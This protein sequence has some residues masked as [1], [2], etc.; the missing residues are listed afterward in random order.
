MPSGMYEGREWTGWEPGYDETSRIRKMLNTHTWEE[1][2]AVIRPPIT[3]E[4]MARV[5]RARGMKA[6]SRRATAHAGT[7]ALSVAM[8]GRAY[9]RL[10]RRR[11]EEA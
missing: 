6:K 8:G 7:S 10:R 4:S 2:H 5:L 11:E 3:P 9:E 1:I